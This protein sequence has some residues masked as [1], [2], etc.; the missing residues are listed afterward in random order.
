[1]RFDTYS[2]LI[3]ILTSTYSNTAKQSV[4][5]LIHQAKENQKNTY[6]DNQLINLVILPLNFLFTIIVNLI[7]YA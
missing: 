3:L 2:Y 5:K 1:M 4:N 6:F 7:Y